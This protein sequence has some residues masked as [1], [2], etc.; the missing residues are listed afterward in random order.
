MIEDMIED[1]NTNRTGG[2]KKIYFRIQF[3]TFPS[4]FLSLNSL[5]LIPDI[6]PLS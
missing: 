2:D 4:Y 5:T 1:T 3:F 6:H